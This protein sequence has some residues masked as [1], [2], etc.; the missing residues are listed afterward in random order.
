MQQQNEG[1]FWFSFRNLTRT[2]QNIMTLFNAVGDD[3][4][5]LDAAM[6]SLDGRV[7][8]IENSTLDPSVTTIYAYDD[9]CDNNREVVLDDNGDAIEATTIY[10]R[11]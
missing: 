5:E 1:T 11:A 4:D 9:V 3:F 7:D 10:N 6:T 8:A 2:I